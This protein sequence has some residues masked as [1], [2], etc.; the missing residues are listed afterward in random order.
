M[1]TV[2]QNFTG[3]VR[4]QIHEQIREVLVVDELAKA[5]ILVKEQFEPPDITVHT[6]YQCTLAIQARQEEIRQIFVNIL[7]NSVQAMGG[8]GSLS[9][10]T[11]CSEDHMNISIQDSGPG[12]PK[13]HASKIFD[14]FF[15]TKRQ[16][17]GAGLG[18]T[19]ARRIV[20]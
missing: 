5:W 20:T 19:V 10:A 2:I 6:L 12:I 14:P 13:P 7:S 4:G 18:L 1:A 11:Q 15:T 8:K 17:E 16:G 3:Q 9:L